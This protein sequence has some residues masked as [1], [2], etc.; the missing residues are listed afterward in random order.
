M[1]DSKNIAAFLKA[2]KAHPFVLT[3][4]P[5]PDPGPNDVVV[6]TKAVAANPIDAM[7]QAKAFMPIPYPTILGMDLAG[8]VAEVGGEVQHL[9]KGDRVIAYVNICPSAFSASSTS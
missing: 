3:A 4:A 2:E 8:V 9:A 1:A 6:E 7:I 5:Y